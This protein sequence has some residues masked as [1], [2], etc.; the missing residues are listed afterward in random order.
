[1]IRNSMVALAAAA[2]SLTTSSAD[3]QRF[4]A[5]ENLNRNA[6]ASAP[7]AKPEEPATGMTATAIVLTSSIGDCIQVAE[8]EVLSGG[9]NVAAASSGGRAS[10]QDIWSNEST[11]DKAI[12]GVKPASYPNIYHS[13]CRG[14][15]YLRVDFASPAKVQSVIAYGRADGWQGRDTFVYQLFSGSTV[16]G[17]GTIDARSGSGSSTPS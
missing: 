8:L 15:S 17:G 14:D 3:A 13:A 4:Y 10:A 12:D 6:T 5:R 7:A 11:A 16:I 9:R 1:M 2:A